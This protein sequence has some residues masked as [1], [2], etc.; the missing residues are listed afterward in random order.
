MTSKDAM[1]AL[2]LS[3]AECQKA[4]LQGNGKPYDKI[5]IGALIPKHNVGEPC[6]ILLL[7]R[8]AHEP[9]YPNKF[10]IPGGKVEDSD[11]TIVDAV[12]REV[13]E[14]TGMEV[15][16]VTGAVSSFDYAAAKEIALEPVGKKA[17]WTVSLQLNF[18]CNVTEH[19]LTVNPEEHSEGKFV[20]NSE[21]GNLD[22]T[23]Q[24]RSVAGEGLAR[25]ANGLEEQKIYLDWY[26]KSVP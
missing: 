3:K 17:I 24:M 14:E 8:A 22:M 15:I 11:P 10:E 23:E 26:G 13:R 1:G 18:I 9:L 25:L 5:V 19:E 4:Y 20:D 6:R 16:N 7:K 2:S 12:K 21:V